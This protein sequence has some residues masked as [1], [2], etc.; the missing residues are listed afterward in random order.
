MRVMKSLLLGAAAGLVATAGAQAADMPVKAKAV[1][2]VKICSAYGAGFYY[3]PGTDICLRVGG[4]VFAEAGVKGR[5]A[6]ISFPYDGGF[7]DIT[8]GGAVNA[9]P[10]SWRNANY[11]NWRSRGHVILDARQNTADGTLRAYFV[12]G[13]SIANPPNGRAPQ[14][15]FGVGSVGASMDRAFIEF[16]G[17]TAGMTESF[18][19]FG[20][21]Y[22]IVSSNALSWDWV[23]LIAYTAQLG[24]GVTASVALED[25]SAYRVG[26]VGG[27]AAAAPFAAVP[28]GG[29]NAPDIV[30]NIR[31]TQAWGS[32]QIMGALHEVRPS[33][34]NINLGREWGWA[35]GAGIEVKTPWS[36]APNNSFLLQGV[37]GKGAIERTGLSG[38][39]LGTSGGVNFAT[40]AFNLADGTV[41]AAGTGMDLTEAWSVYAGY[42]HYWTPALRT[43]FAFGYVDLEPSS[44]V[45]VSDANL[46]QAHVSTIWSPVAGLDLSLDIVWTD[47]EA[48]AFATGASTSRDLWTAWY[49][50]RRNF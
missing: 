39:P 33:A 18:F 31:V 23:N 42:R 50:I 41:N 22:S 45:V 16:A 3:I 20:G 19:S 17:F 36:G 1:E 11:T 30:G 25:G 49:R 28:Y 48:T 35:I 2:Y 47:I 6:A 10:A 5:N 43:G 9:T 13:V 27:A 40:A 21:A 44:G 34:A 46:M 24:N 15:Q 4:Y 14:G 7:F 32:A 26:G 8:G 37:Y 29:N 12:G 38:S